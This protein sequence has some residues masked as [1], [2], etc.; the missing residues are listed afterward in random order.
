MGLVA[1]FDGNLWRLHGGK[2]AEVLW[3]GTKDD[4]KK[5]SK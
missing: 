3:E 4:L 5:A 2:K 1:S